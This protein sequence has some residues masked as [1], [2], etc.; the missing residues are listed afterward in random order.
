MD[1]IDDNRLINTLKLPYSTSIPYRFPEDVESYTVVSPIGNGEWGDERWEFAFKGNKR[2]V[3]WYYDAN[4]AKRKNLFI[5]IVGALIGIV[6]SEISN[7]LREIIGK[8]LKNLTYTRILFY[9]FVIGLTF[10]FYIMLM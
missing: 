2:R 8:K 3:F 7:I 5:L 6:I 9:I 1:D 4:D 10:Y